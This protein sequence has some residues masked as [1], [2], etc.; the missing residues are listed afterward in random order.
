MRNN[1]IL[2]VLLLP[3][4]ALFASCEVE[5][6]PN[7][8]WKEVP[9]VYCVLDQDT[10]AT[11][12]RVEKCFLSEDAFSQYTTVMDST[13]YPVGSL[14]VEIRVWKDANAMQNGTPL[15]VMTFYDTVV[16]KESGEFAS[17][18]GQHVFK[19]RNR[20]SEFNPAYLYE[21][22]VKRVATGDV[23][24]RATTNL[25]GGTEVSPWLESPRPNTYNASFGFT[26]NK[27]CVIQWHEFERGRLYQPIVTFCYL[28]RYGARTRKEI[29]IRCSATK[30]NSVELQQGTFL[31]DI[32]NALAGDT[33]KKTFYDTVR[34]SL[35]VCNED[36]SAYMSSTQASG[37]LAQGQQ[38]YSNIEG[39][40]GVFGARRS[41]LVVWVGSDKS[42]IAPSGLHYL[43]RELN[44]G[45]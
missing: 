24:A 8:D 28:N 5:F 4:V 22:V 44:V 41:G 2:W 33:C 21:L 18:E 11:Y 25:V 42:D 27:K 35:K 10:S 26:Y 12:V 43:L 6:S 23:I 38:I 7:A 45:F 31:L 20:G 3:F 30:G 37:S 17:A 13:Q 1:R 9:A 36:L 34:I 15:A 32:K 29:D 14:D 16:E 39:G 40:V 19:H